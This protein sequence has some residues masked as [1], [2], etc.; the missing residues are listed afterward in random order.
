MGGYL[1]R[2]YEED[3]PLSIDPYEPGDNSKPVVQVSPDGKYFINEFNSA[4][5]AKEEVSIA[6]HI[7]DCCIGTRAT[8]GGYQWRFA[9][10]YEYNLPV[11]L[12]THQFYQEQARLIAFEKVAES[13]FKPVAQYDIQGTFIRTF[14]SVRDAAQSTGTD[15]TSLIQCCSGRNKSAG[16][17]IWRRILNGS[18]EARVRPYLRKKDLIPTELGNMIWKV[19][20]FNCIP[21]W[22]VSIRWQIRQLFWMCSV[23]ARKLLEAFSGPSMMEAIEFLR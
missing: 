2:A 20:L 6:S 8:A 18:P 4:T 9:E 23:D 7:T 14:D 21:T 16:G 1:W 10:D 17:F 22:L 11:G 19:D 3:Y 15:R 5:E 13:K 12:E